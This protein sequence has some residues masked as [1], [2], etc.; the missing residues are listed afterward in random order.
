MSDSPKQHDFS[1]LVS[2]EVATSATAVYVMDQLDPAP[3]LIVGPALESNRTYFNAVLSRQRANQASRARRK[4]TPAMVKADRDDDR[5]LYPHH[6]VRGWERGVTA[7]VVDE[8]TGKVHL[9]DVPFSAEAAVGFIE[10][11]PDW[12]FDDLRAF[13][14]N[15]FNFAG[16]VDV[17]DQVGNSPGG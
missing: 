11:L 7:R 8:G 15:P 16:A 9:V 13:C 12:V 5:K 4:V 10:A 3:R 2:A 6:I 17:E 14:Q 1:H